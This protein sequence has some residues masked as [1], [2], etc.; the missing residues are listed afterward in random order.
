MSL[1]KKI[2]YFGGWLDVSQSLSGMILALFL[3][4]HLLL[5]GV[6]I[7]RRRCDDYGGQNHGA[8]LPQC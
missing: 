5:S 8:E 3:W 7:I 1:T 6:D 2:N 4:T